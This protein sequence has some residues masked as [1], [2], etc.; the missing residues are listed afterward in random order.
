MD[1]IAFAA[2]AS[3]IALYAILAVGWVASVVY[4]ALYAVGR[5]RNRM[6][7]Q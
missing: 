4:L 2:I 7:G 1:V 5:I 6:R 3:R